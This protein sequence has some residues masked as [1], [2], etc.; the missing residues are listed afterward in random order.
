M[1]EDTI[2]FRQRVSGSSAPLKS[3]AGP[4][5]H[6][7]THH[8]FNSSLKEPKE[9]PTPVL[10]RDPAVAS[11]PPAVQPHSDDLPVIPVAQDEQVNLC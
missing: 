1:E 3:S 6:T 9:Q 5:A 8:G 4:P 11:A 10:R 2:P 7:P